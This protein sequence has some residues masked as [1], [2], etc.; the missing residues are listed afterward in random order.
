MRARRAS[1][2]REGELL[3]RASKL[4]KDPTLLLPKLSRNCPTGRFD[5]L[6]AALETVHEARDDA[7]RLGR[8]S[9][10]GDPMARSLAGVFKFYLDEELPG[11]LVARYPAGELSF[12]PLAKAPRESQIAVQQYDHPERLVLGYLSWARK[13][14]H[15]FAAGKT[16][17]CTGPSPEPP[18]EFRHAFLS[19]LPYRLERGSAAGTFACPHLIRGEPV[20]YLEVDWP[21]AAM[22]FRVCRRC[23]RDDRQLLAALTSRLAVPKPEKAFPVTFALNVD[24]RSKEACVHA[25]LPPPSRRVRKAYL[26]GR[27][28]D[29]KALDDYRKELAPR[30]EPGRGARFEAAGVCYGSD[31]GAFV[32]ALS[33]TPAERK[34]LEEALPSVVGAF[35][36]PD[37]TASQALERL[38][39][40]H[41][42]EIVRAIVPEPARAEQLV[43]DARAAPGRVSELLHRAAR[44]TQERAL[45]SRLPQFERLVPAAAMAD[46]VA[47]A[48]RT[49]GR[50][51]AAKLL[52]AQLPREG[53]ERGIGFG[54]LVAMDQANA[55]LWQFTPTEQEFGRSLA[56]RAGRLL[57]AEPTDYA[58]ALGELLGAAGVTDWGVLAANSP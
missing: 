56:E 44:E 11:I 3:Q 34:A 36:L 22:T 40:D 30:L 37:A 32:D 46:R 43:R 19:D 12:A 15:F 54:L 31:L 14:Y 51:A 7:D 55:Q 9:R 38:W 57:R 41:A 10:R 26:F 2:G 53:K 52:L 47:R 23:A 13:G 8:L 33:P 18:D 39:H 24:C 20:P 6:R 4:R 58:G 29:A 27:L 25:A 21:G 35:E 49:G 45:L 48:Y 16:L 1:G 50:E 5:R 42:E 17:Y 28:S